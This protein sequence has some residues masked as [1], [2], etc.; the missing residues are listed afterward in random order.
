MERPQATVKESSKSVNPKDQGPSALDP[1][2]LARGEHDVPILSTEALLKISQD[3]A[4]VL[5]QLTAP[6]APID[7]IRKHEVEEFQGTSL[8]ESDKSDF[9]LEKLKKALD[10]VKCP[11]EQMIKCAISLLE[12]ASYDW[13]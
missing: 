1:F 3:M 5:D 12:G 8:E 6:R 9:L 10:E 4:K 13:W 11:P 7:S 2:E